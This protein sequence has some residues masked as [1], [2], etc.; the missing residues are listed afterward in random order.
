MMR[1]LVT[2]ANSFL[3]RHV[4]DHLVRRGHAVTGTYRTEGEATERL[5]A[6]ASR[7]EL[8]AVDLADAAAFSRLPKRVDAVIHIAGVS[9]APGVSVGDMLACNVGGARNLADYA[10]SAGAS[11]LLYASTLSVHGRI[12][13]QVVDES[14][15]VRAPDVYGASKLLAERLFAAHSHRLPCMAVRLPGVLG[16]GA[17]R[18]WLPTLLEDLQVGREVTIYGP[19]HAFNNAAHVEDLSSLFDNALYALF[20]GFCA[21]PVGA[22]GSMTIQALVDKLHRL[23]RSTSRVRV[24]EEAKPGFTISSAYA[25][26]HFGYRPKDI[27]DMIEQYY[28]ECRQ[29]DGLD[30]LAAARAG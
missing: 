27:C 29:A 18:A 8:V 12:V 15:P 21:F 19:D 17:H 5:R 26:R 14:T 24:V 20:S 30:C 16:S 1:V 6:L 11:R 3:G 7:P 2:G 23:T 25:K 9:I 22:D 4:V 13:E 28:S 10:L